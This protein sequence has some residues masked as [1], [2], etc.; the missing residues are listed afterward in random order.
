V[1]D[2]HPAI[3]QACRAALPEGVAAQRRH[4]QAQRTAARLAARA[5]APAQAALAP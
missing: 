5:L 3:E 1:F 4:S 2:L